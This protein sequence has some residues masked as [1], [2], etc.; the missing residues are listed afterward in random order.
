MPNKDNWYWNMC[1]IT[2]NIPSASKNNVCCFFRYIL[3][4]ASVCLGPHNF[5]SVFWFSRCIPR[6]G[7]MWNPWLLC[8]VGLYLHCID[9]LQV[10]YTHILSGHWELWGY[11]HLLEEQITY[12]YLTHAGLSVFISLVSSVGSF[13]LFIHGTLCLDVLFFYVILI[14]WN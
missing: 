11:F 13:I 5:P 7:G 4:F 3:I 8:A 10:S 6:N 14:R 12:F 9:N 1:Q 2:G